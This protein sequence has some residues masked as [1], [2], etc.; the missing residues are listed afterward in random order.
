MKGGLAMRMTPETR[1]RAANT[2]NTPHFSFRIKAERTMTRTGEEKRMVVESPRGSLAK[3]VKMKRIRRP[4]VRAS[5][6][7]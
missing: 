7:R 2:L 1:M 4:P 6:N 5:K 3:L